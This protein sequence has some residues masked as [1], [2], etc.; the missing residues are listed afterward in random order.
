MYID[1]APIPAELRASISGISFQS[2]LEGADR[3]ELSIVNENLRWLDHP[4][5]AMDRE[6]RLELGYAEKSIQQ[7]F[8]GNIVS[9]SATFPNGGGPILTVSSQDK[10]HALQQDKKTRWFAI[11]KASGGYATLPDQFV[12]AI[13]AAEHQLIPIADPIGAALSVILGG[14]D[15]VAKIEGVA[16]A[17]RMVRYQ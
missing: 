3:V 2:G 11:P 1:G 13:A 15:A 4:S 9:C 16:D 5:L 6:I 12:T 17:Q 7:V 8:V 10:I 14:I